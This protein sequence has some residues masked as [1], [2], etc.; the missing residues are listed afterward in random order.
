M[1]IPIYLILI[2][3]FLWIFYN[4]FFQVEGFENCKEVSLGSN[5]RKKSPDQVTN[6]SGEE[7]EIYKCKLIKYKENQENPT[8]LKLALRQ[9]KKLLPIIKKPLTSIEKKFNELKDTHF[10]WKSSKSTR[11]DAIDKLYKFVDGEEKSGNND[12]CKEKPESCEEVDACKKDKNLCKGQDEIIQN[13][14]ADGKPMVTS[15]ENE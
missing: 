4:H 15:F 6:L 14:G 8:N 7:K 3:L 13:G 2:F 9:T 12:H 10:K 11:D 1:E 5:F